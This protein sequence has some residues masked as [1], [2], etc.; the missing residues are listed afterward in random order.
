LQRFERANLLPSE[1]LINPG[2]VSV[3]I[4]G[5]GRVGSGAYD[6]LHLRVSDGLLGVD[7][8][9]YTVEQH[10]NAGRHVVRGS[11]TDP[12][13]WERFQ[14]D[15]RAVSLVMLA[16]PNQQENLYA[17]NQLRRSGYTGKLAAIAKYP[18]D[19]EA[20]RQ[21]GA[22]SV[23]NLYAEAGTGFANHASDWLPETNQAL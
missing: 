11:V 15:H 10:R 12:D 14:I 20:L 21:A 9:R 4:F 22:D 16:M 5:M 17:V 1:Q 18:D 2:N 6:A 19:L 23:F 13:F 8:D 3:I 7:F